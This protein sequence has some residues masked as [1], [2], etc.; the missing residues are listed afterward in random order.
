[1]WAVS[2]KAMKELDAF[3]TARYGIPPAVLMERAGLESAAWI[4][5]RCRSL[6]N[7]G[8]SVLILAGKGNNGGDGAV[9]AR[10]LHRKG[11]AVQVVLAASLDSLSG[12][13]KEEFRALSELS[14]PVYECKQK[15][16]F[17]RVEELFDRCAVVIDALLGIGLASPV[18]SPLRELIERV[19]ER[20]SGRSNRCPVISVDLPSGLDA[21]RGI[22]CG[23][24]ISADVTLT[25]GLPKVGLLT[26]P[27]KEYAGEIVV[28]DIGI[29][30]ELIRTEMERNKIRHEWLLSEDAADLIPE[31]S[32]GIHKGEAGKVLVLGGSEG[33]LGAA[34]MTAEAALRIGAGLVRLL[35]AKEGALALDAELREVMVEPFPERK[36]ELTRVIKEHDGVAIGPG[37][38]KSEQAKRL[39][40]W[41][42]E[43]S[44]VPVV[45]DADGINLVAESLVL[46]K[47]AKGPLVLTPHPGEMARLLKTDI[48]EIQM[49]RLE[50][51]EKFARKYRCTLVLK[52]NG[53]VIAHPDGTVQINS[54]GGPHL[55]TVGTGDVLTGVIAGLIAQ[56]ASPGD[57]ASLGVFVHG[58]AADLKSAEIGDRGLLATD[59]L[60][61]LP[62]ALKFLGR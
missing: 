41:V 52:G 46:L 5:R 35:T 38:G 40:S 9:I 39:L 42:L 3:T 53:T 6:L 19:N 18:R 10:E 43:M 34:A 31:R 57:A 25:M 15:D 1:M 32:P 24:A 45:I 48:E 26:T 36:E 14:I 29:P 49:N 37:L 50:V 56:G 51:A 54:T 23:M 4:L 59:L 62:K 2:S 58:Y 60:A 20:C 61:L 17:A 21:D 33:K 27:G 47:K 16:D 12:L 8:K 55:A 44:P 30:L 13:P 22:P 11:V 28:I 7:D